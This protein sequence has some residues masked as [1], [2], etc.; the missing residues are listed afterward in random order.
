MLAGRQAKAQRG[1]IISLLP[2]G[3]IR[4]PSG[5]VVLDP[6]EQVQTT[7][8]LIFDIFSRYGSVNGVLG[9]LVA[10]DIQLP[11]RVRDGAAKGDLEWRRPSRTT[12]QDMLHNPAYA[13]AV[14]PESPMFHHTW[15]WVA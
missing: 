2:R 11:C 1:E 3:Y 6:D 14:R 7:I 5:D 12:L 4:R 13:G 9:Y 8:R 15:A 10:H